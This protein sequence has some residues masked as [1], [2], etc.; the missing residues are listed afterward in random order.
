[1]KSIETGSTNENDI[2]GSEDLPEGWKITYLGDVC[3]PPQYGW[4]TSSEKN[5]YGLKIVRTS[6]IS[7]GEI[8]W[9][10]VPVCK[11]EPENI[12]KFL[13][14]QGDILISRAGSVGTSFI[15][16]DCPRAVFASYLIRFRALPSIETNYLGL[17]LKSR[18]YW[19]SIAGETIG[20]TI[21]NVNA[22]KLKQ[23]P[24]PLPP[25]AEQRRIVARVEALLSHVD[26]AGDHEAVPAVGA[27]VCV[28]REVDGGVEGGESLNRH[29]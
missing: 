3:T 5:A 29:F 7:S 22:S 25:I 15:I 2:S 1:M 26:A 24:I 10:T 21:P 16:K 13:L 19:D 18:L 11:E 17:F 12:D 14:K 8:D 28:F 23:I 9:S 6:D 4:T 27:G 20:I